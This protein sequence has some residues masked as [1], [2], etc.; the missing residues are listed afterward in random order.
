[1]QNFVGLLLLP[2][3]CVK[4]EI[5]LGDTSPISYITQWEQDRCYN[6]LFGLTHGRTISDNYFPL[7]FDP[8]CHT[9]FV[10]DHYITRAV[11]PSSLL[12]SSETNVIFNVWFGLVDHWHSLGLVCFVWYHDKSENNY[13]Y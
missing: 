1:M 11:R 13:H 9:H 5:E 12:K 10:S 6:D 2:Q 8:P 4:I 3:P 7:K